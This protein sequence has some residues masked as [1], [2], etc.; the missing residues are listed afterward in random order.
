MA[1]DCND[2]SH[3]QCDDEPTIRG[4]ALVF[5]VIFWDMFYGRRRGSSSSFVP[6][7]IG[8]V[9]IHDWMPMPDHKV[10]RDGTVVEALNAVAQAPEIGSARCYDE[11]CY[12]Q[13][14]SVQAYLRQGR[15]VV[16]DVGGSSAFHHRFFVRR[17]LCPSPPSVIE[18]Y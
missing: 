15:D 10:W 14:P 8:W 18:N 6:Y 2:R 7:W 3:H 5:P 1:V 4:V 11:D 16:A 12:W 17:D 9:A 13:Q